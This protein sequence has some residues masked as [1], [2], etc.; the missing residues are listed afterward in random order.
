MARKSPWLIAFI[1]VTSLLVL[2]LLLALGFS[3]SR[4]FKHDQEEAVMRRQSQEV[5][6]P[7]APAKVAAPHDPSASRGIA[8]AVLGEG[9]A[10]MAYALLKSLETTLPV[11]LWYTDTGPGALEP[12]TL[13]KFEGLAT[14]HRLV[15]PYHK[16]TTKCSVL[17]NTKLDEVLLLDADVIVYGEIT[18]ELF[19]DEDFT[20]E[21]LLYFT[22]DD[23]PRSAV[24][25]VRKACVSNAYL[26][27]R[28]M[29]HHRLDRHDFLCDL[30]GAERPAH[31]SAGANGYDN[32]E[33]FKMGN[34]W[35][36]HRHRQRWPE[37]DASGTWDHVTL[38]ENAVDLKFSQLFGKLDDNVVS[39][40]RS[41]R[42]S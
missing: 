20:R 13:G 15:P 42:N 6:V 29:Y 36:L 27:H 31:G 37:V 10:E 26:E 30:G 5:Q 12:G 23:E 33:L 41:F 21:G 28:D 2:L 39:D 34:V 7:A 16:Y 3:A 17:A 9:Y 4:R 32:T 22:N 18:D 1:V 11:E 14:L 25:L 38:A 8:V 24:M 35:F 40:L 19:E